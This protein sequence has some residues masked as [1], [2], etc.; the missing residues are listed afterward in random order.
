MALTLHY[1]YTRKLHRGEALAYDHHCISVNMLPCIFSTFGHHARHGLGD[2]TGQDTLQK[3]AGTK[4]VERKHLTVGVTAM[5]FTLGDKLASLYFFFIRRNLC[6]YH[7]LP[8]RLSFHQS[9][10][11]KSRQQ[12]RLCSSRV[13][14][15][16]CLALLGFLL[17][18]FNIKHLVLLCF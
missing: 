17:F 15:C 2:H 1:L 8:H 10:K 14:I 6:D 16:L 18:C 11:K 7:F 3:S 5:A 13:F 4:T 12:Q 9:Q